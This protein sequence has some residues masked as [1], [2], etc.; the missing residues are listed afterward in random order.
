MGIVVA[1][2]VGG[3]FGLSL[4]FAF[5]FSRAMALGRREEPL[6]RASEDPE[7]AA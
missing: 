5:F 3:W 1:V 7:R 6:D 4:V 2:V